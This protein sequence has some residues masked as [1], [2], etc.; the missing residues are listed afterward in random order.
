MNFLDFKVFV[1]SLIRNKLYSIITIIGFAVSL[2]FVILLSVYIRQELSVDDFHVNK[3]RIVRME[4][5][6]G[7]N[8][9]ALVAQSVQDAFP[10]VEAYTRIYETNSG[11]TTTADGNKLGIHTL[12][13]DTAFLEMF[14][15]PVVERRNF[16][17]KKEV[18]ISHSF[19]RKMFGDE[20]ALGKDLNYYGNTGW[21]IVGIFEDFPKNT[22]FKAC[23]ALF[24]FNSMDANWIGNNNSS[25]FATYLMTKPGTELTSKIPLMLEFLKKDFWMYKDNYRQQLFLEPLKEV[26]WSSKA[27]YGIHRNS[28]TFVSV[29]MAI[30][31]VILILALINYNNLSVARVSF[32]AKESA[33]K[34]LLGSNNTALFRQFVMESVSLCYAAFVLAC[35][36]VVSVTPWFNNL[37]ETHIELSQHITLTTVL[38]TLLG[39]GIIGLIAGIIPAFIISRFNPVAVVKGAFRKKTKGIYSKALISFQYCV[40]ITLIICTLVIWK[41]T[42]FMRNYKLG[43]NKEN[44][45]WLDNKISIQQKEALQSEF[46]RIPGVQLVSF[47]RGTPI[48]GGNNQTMTNYGGTGKQISFQQFEVDSNFFNMLEL[49]IIPTGAAYDKDGVWLNETAVKAIESGGMPQEFMYYEQKCPVLGIVK[50]FHIDDLTSEIEPLII[51]PIKPDQGFWTILVKISSENPA[52]TFE[53][54]KKTYSHFID[55]EPFD[56]GFM[57][58]T[59]ND[60]YESEA[61]TARLVGYFSLL[62]IVLCMMGILAMATYFIQQRIKEIGVRRVNG[63][64]INEILYML[65]SNFMKWIVLAFVLA[66]PLAWYI[67]NRWLED[68]PYRMNLGLWLFLGAGGIA[69]FIAALIVGWQSV[70]AASENPV[71]ALQN[72]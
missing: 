52:G 62:A 36:L 46:E 67:M 58:R 14:S 69:F 66:C 47:V 64:T 7:A 40:A 72:E 12:F 23:D 44:I 29:M 30:V 51:A 53:D 19:A 50:D 41:Q 49:E 5:E 48:D 13:V 33:I 70:K 21:L 2:T 6:E 37:L 35:I 57:D 4:G 63:A 43:Y 42:D 10:E 38:V 59:L 15:F 18:V 11:Y 3:D 61:H 32:R 27:T 68:F 54:I 8:W 1:R 39:V 20:P 65:M 17:A 25:A 60:W 9:G 16:K 22:Q 45:V 55:R 24:N 34:K 71:K 28:R 56:S 31:G 26:Y